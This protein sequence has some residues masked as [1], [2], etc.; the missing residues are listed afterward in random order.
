MGS[1]RIIAD[2]KNK[3][4]Q[5]AV[6]NQQSS[7]R[8]TAYDIDRNSKY[9]VSPFKWYGFIKTAK[10]DSFWLEIAWSYSIRKVELWS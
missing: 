3:K 6:V 5:S 4:K 7:I 10:T 1:K 9:P 2:R 8:H